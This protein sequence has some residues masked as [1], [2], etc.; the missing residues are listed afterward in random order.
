[1]SRNPM[2]SGAPR[3]VLFF[4]ALFAT[5]VLFAGWG[6]SNALAQTTPNQTVPPGP[7][8]IVVVLHAAPFAAD[9]ADTAVDI[10]TED[11]ELVEGLT[12][13]T[14]LERPGVNLSAGTFDWMIAEGGTN[15]ATELLD[16]DPFVIRNLSHFQLLISGDGANQPLAVTLIAIAEGEQFIY[17]PVIS[18]TSTPG[19]TPTPEVTPTPEE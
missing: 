9:P 11:G 10:C 6:A 8:G 7:L 5:I 15:C 1:M 18:L 19:E 17:M 4:T 16:V 12:D 13:I 14:Y 2:F 3:R